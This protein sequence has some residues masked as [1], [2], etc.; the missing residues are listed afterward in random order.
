MDE[1][2]LVVEL[3]WLLVSV[4]GDERLLEIWMNELADCSQ[5][6]LHG[7]DEIEAGYQSV[8][9]CWISELKKEP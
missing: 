9:G 7:S 8:C 2:K 3:M 1:V 4:V 5:R 6:V